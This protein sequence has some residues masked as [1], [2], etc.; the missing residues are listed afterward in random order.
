MPFR[1]IINKSHRKVSRMRRIT[2]VYRLE[3]QSDM[4]VFSTKLCELCPSNLLSGSPPPPL[5][6]SQSQS[7]ETV[8]C[9]EGWERVLSYVKDHILQ[10]LNTRFFTSFRTYTVA[11]P[12]L[13]KT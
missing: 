5:P 1:K 13:T 6:H 12:P 10:E 11:T 3:V 8:N 4:S 7:T 2:G 9:C